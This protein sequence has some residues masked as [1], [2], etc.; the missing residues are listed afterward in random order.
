MNPCALW[1]D[2]AGAVAAAFEVEHS[3]S[4]Y[5]GIVRLLDLALG[6]G[7]RATRELFLVAPDDRE[8]EVRAQVARPAFGHIARSFRAI[9]RARPEPGGDG[10]F[11]ARA[12]GYS[13]RSPATVVKAS[14]SAS[15]RTLR[16]TLSG[17]NPCLTATFEPGFIDRF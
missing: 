17:S 16:T 1:L 11:W 10:T 9:S 7:S 12:E 8:D 4:I 2:D 3:T 14:R 6:G 5:S 15:C 13:C